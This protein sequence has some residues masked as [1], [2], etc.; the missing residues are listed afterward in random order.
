M[1]SAPAPS[2]LA[3]ALLVIGS[4]CGAPACAGEEE[5]L[6]VEASSYHRWLSLHCVEPEVSVP[7]LYL[8]DMT[9]PFMVM[10]L[11]IV[12]PEGRPAILTSTVDALRGIET[13]RV[14]DNATGW[15]SQVELNWPFRGKTVNEYTNRFIEGADEAQAE[16]GWELTASFETRDGL[17]FHGDL[18]M[19]VGVER[20]WIYQEIGHR[21]GQEGQDE[22]GRSL[23][24]GFPRALS[25]LQSALAPAA[26]DR[27]RDLALAVLYAIEPQSLAGLLAASAGTADQAP[28]AETPGCREWTLDLGEPVKGIT[29]VDAQ[30]LE[31]T[32]RFRGVQNA[33]PLADKRAAELQGDP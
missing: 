33:N 21:L 31:F 11:L 28:E 30:D 2:H 5:E 29:F 13:T 4:L 16:G 27:E 19:P 17:L 3:M 32:A 7:G 26:G 23:P 8:F 10:R 1:T 24:R 12:S 9:R 25:F 20:S 22:L 15:W 6:G 14:E 18:R